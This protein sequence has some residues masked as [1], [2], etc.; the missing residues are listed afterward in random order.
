MPKQI[1]FN[2]IPLIGDL[3]RDGY[4]KEEEKIIEETRKILDDPGIQVVAT[5]V[6]VPT[7]VGHAVSVNVEFRSALDLRRIVELWSGFEGVRYTED[8]PTPIDVTG[9]DEVFVG[10]LRR[11]ATRPH[12]VTYWAVGD[13]LR[14]GA[15]TNSVQIAELMT[16]C[17]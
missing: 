17:A 2:C 13:N 3:G 15:A 5:A 6:R 14:K 11:D 4:T 16:S 8:V 7:R 9:K 1:A 12:A 10:R